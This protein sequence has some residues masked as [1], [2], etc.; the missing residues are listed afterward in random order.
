MVALSP[1][2]YRYPVDW[3]APDW[4]THDG[5]LERILE[6]APDLVITGE[7]NA[8]T[9]RTRLSELGVHVEVLPLPR[10]LSDITDYEARLLSLLGLP[11][12]RADGEVASAEVRQNGKRLLLLGANGIG[13]GRQTFEHDVIERAGW[14]NYL[15][16]DG[17]IPLDLEQIASDP[18][19]AVVWAAPDAAA[20]ANRFAEHRVLRKAVPAERWVITDYWRWQCPGPWTWELVK[21]LQ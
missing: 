4:P 12:D 14:R 8:L 3:V 5:R 10:S 20:L 17:Y 18:P 11:L 13:T 1:Y 15:K 16:H 6:L 7:L 21:E 19:D 2:V 9:L